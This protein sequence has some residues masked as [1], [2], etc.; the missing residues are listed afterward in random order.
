MREFACGRNGKVISVRWNSDEEGNMAT[1]SLISAICAPFKRKAPALEREFVNP[2][3]A[4]ADFGAQEDIYHESDQPW[5]CM[6][7]IRNRPCCDCAAC[8]E[9]RLEGLRRK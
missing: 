8:Q 4:C 6:A 1:T 5:R 7:V 3:K 2:C 9:N